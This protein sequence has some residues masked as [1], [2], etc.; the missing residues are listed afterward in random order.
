MC[1]I[2]FK[3]EKSNACLH[4]FLTQSRYLDYSTQIKY[5]Q[6]H[7]MVHLLCILW[8]FLKP[9][10]FHKIVLH[11]KLNKYCMIMNG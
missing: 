6:D 10:H 7:F 11:S 3:V 8:V 9:Q 5:S 1:K 4:L 2:N